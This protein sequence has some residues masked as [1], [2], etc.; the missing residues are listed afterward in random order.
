[1]NDQLIAQ[2]KRH[3]GKVTQ[4]G[5]HVPYQ[6]HLGY[7]T[8]GYGRLIDPKLG[9]G[10]SEGEAMFNLRNDLSNVYG[11]LTHAYPWIEDLDAARRDVLINMC[12]NMGL[13]RLSKFV[14]ML[15]AIRAGAYE[16]AASELL[17]SRYASQ[18]GARANELAE[19]MVSGEYQ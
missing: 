7:W 12:F 14:K 2:I 16:E 17:D 4:N 19:Q 8:I 6:D 15:A 1:M 11:E 13:T 18:V 10:I 9:G 5:K 3:E